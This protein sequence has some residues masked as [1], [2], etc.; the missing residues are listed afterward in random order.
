MMFTVRAL[1]GQTSGSAVLAPINAPASDVVVTART[2]TLGG[3][4]LSALRR[5]VIDRMV[6]EGGW[7][8]NDMEREIR[9]RRV[10]VVIAQTGARERLTFYFT[11]VEG[12]LYRLATST[13]NELNEP[14]AAASEHLVST[15]RVGGSTTT[16]LATQ[17]PR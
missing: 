11:E 12:N 6:A 3:V 7:V 16:A 9:G 17:R 14:A 13:P 1:D 8:V 10:Y 5:T 15:F 2:K 4:P